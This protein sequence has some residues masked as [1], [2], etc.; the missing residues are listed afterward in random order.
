MSKR[1]NLRRLIGLFVISLTLACNVFSQAT[2]AARTTPG[3]KPGPT[4]TAVQ[5]TRPPSSGTLAATAEGTSAFGH[6]LPNGSLTVRFNEPMNPASADIPILTYPYVDGQPKWTENNSVVTFQPAKRFASD[7]AYVVSVNPYLTNT[8]GQGFNQPPTWKL[9]TPSAPVVLGHNPATGLIDDRRPTIRVAFDRAMD[10]A[11]VAASLSVTPTV[12]FNVTWEKQDGADILVIH[13]QQAF[14]AGVRYTFT[15]GRAAADAEGVAMGEDYRWS[16]WLDG[17]KVTISREGDAAD[18]PISFV[19]N[20]PMDTQSVDRAFKIDPPV[21]GNLVWDANGSRASLRPDANLTPVTTYTVSYTAN[22]LDRDGNPIA[23]PAPLQFATPP[24]VRGDANFGPDGNTSFIS[25][26]FDRAVNHASVAAAFHIEPDIPGQLHWYENTLTLQPDDGALQ[27]LSTYTITLGTSATDSQGAPFLREPFIYS[28]ETDQVYQISVGFGMGPNAQVLDSA[29]RRAVQFASN[30]KEDIPPVNFELYRLSLEQFLERYSSS[31]RGVAGEKKTPISTAGAALVTEWQTAFTA[32]PNSFGLRVSETLIPADVPPGLY[33]LKLATARNNDYLLLVLTRHTLALKQSGGQ[34]VTWVSDINGGSVAGIDVGIYARNG[35]ALAQGQT[36]AN[37]VYETSVALDPAPLIVVARSGDDVTVAGLGSEWRTSTGYWWGWWSDAPKAADYAAYIYTDRPIYRPGQ[38]VFFKAL[39]RRD[40]DAALSVPPAGVKATVRLRDARNNVASSMELETNALGSVNGQFVLSDGAMLGNNYAIEVSVGNSTFRQI[41]KVQDYR[42]PDYEVTVTTDAARYVIGDAIKVTLDTRYFFGEPVPGASLTI[43]QYEL[44]RRYWWEMDPSSGEDTDPYTWYQNFGVTPVTAQTDANGHY[45]LTLQATGSQFAQVNDWETGIKYSTWGIEVTVDDGS[46][47]TVSAF[48]VVDVYE[49]AE[50]LT[51]DVGDYLKKPGAAFTLR[52]RADTIFDTPVANRALKLELHAYDYKNWNFNTVVQTIDL[53][54]GSDGRVETSITPPAPGY[55]E[56]ALTGTDARGRPMGVQRWMYVYDRS[57]TWAGRY[58][59]GLRV[60]ADKETY[61]PGDTARLIVESAFSG[62]ALLTFER[63]ATRREQPAMLTAP[64]TV[65]NVPIQAGDAP[66]IFVAVNAWEPQDTAL[67][68]DTSTSLADSRLQSAS[69]ELSVPVTDKTLTVTLIPDKTEYTPREQAT[70]KVRVTD[71]QGKPVSAEV[72]L[73]LVDEAIFSLSDE[74]S[75]PI[76]EAFYYNR[77]NL[78][79]TYDSMQP[80]R[81]LFAGGMGGGGGGAAGAGAPRSN[82]PD[83]AAWYPELQTDANGEVSIT[84]DLPDSLT[85]WRLT[86]KAHTASTQVGEAYINV[87]TKQPIIVSPA[88]PRLL[89]AG[90]E[91]QISAIVHNYSDKVQALKVT[92]SAG[93]AGLEISGDASQALGLIPG[94]QGIITWTV[95]A[96]S[97]G[98]VPLTFRAQGDGVEDAIRLTLPIQALA[99]P[100]LHTETGEF[101][102]VLNTTVYLPD[103]ALD[104]SSVKIELSRS[105]AGSLLTGLD[106]LTGFPYGCVEQTMSRA[107]PNA[108]VGRAFVQLGVGNPTLQADLPAKI[109][110]GLQRLYGYQH[111]D[112]GWGWWYDD[113]TNDYQTAWVIF[114]LS[115]TAEA[116]YPVD[117]SVVDRGSR[118]LLENLASMDSRTRAFALYSLAQAGQGD[119]AATQTLAG[120]GGELDTFSQAALALAFHRLGAQ[121]EAQQMLDRLAEAAVQSDG[122]VYWPSPN[123]DGHYYQKTMASATR[124]T[125]LALDAFVRI[126]PGHALEPGIVRWLMS[127]RKQ[128]GWGSTNETSFTILALTDH[129]LATETA[130]AE[131]E[132]E[133]TLGGAKIASG[134][135]GRGEPAV[136]L[137]VPASQISHALSLLTIKQGGAGRLYYTISARTYLATREINAAGRVAVQRLY[138]E[139]RSGQALHTVTAG[140]LVKVQLMVD[141][142]DDGAYMLVED[143]LPGGLEALNENLNITS[144]DSAAPLT[145]NGDTIYFWQGLGY[146]YKEVRGDR[147]TFFITEMATG[148]HTFTYL[149]RATHT[150]QFAAMPVEVSAMYNPRMWGRS[151]SDVFSISN[152]TVVAPPPATPT[153]VS[154]AV[155][156][157]PTPV[158]P[159]IAVLN[160]HTSWVSSVAYS[161]DGRLIA[162]GSDDG[163]VILWDALSHSLLATLTGHTQGVL[164]VAF[165]ADGKWLASS[166]K[167]KTIHLW[168]VA[169]RRDVRTLEGHTAPVWSVA[170]SP[171][172]PQLASGSEDGTIRIWDVASGNLVRQLDS[173]GEKIWN[174]AYSVDGAAIVAAGDRVRLWQ[175]ATG[176]AGL[177]LE[178]SATPEGISYAYFSPDGRTLATAGKQLQLWDVQ[179]GQLLRTF[180]GHTAWVWSV[181]F[182]P[183]GQRLVSGSKDQTVRLWNAG[184]GELLQTYS[185][186]VG[187]ANAVAFAP[188]GSTVASA[189]TDKTVRIWRGN[190]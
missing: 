95:K 126:A 97:A 132:Y 187:S 15:L 60:S 35:Q 159:L 140:Q 46:H 89:T 84:L 16:Y 39:L 135:L 54:T 103:E 72:S 139:P 13:P 115:V 173:P 151:A 76:F 99:V 190:P 31:F 44:M 70:F 37:G 176:K 101:A 86:A 170:F 94:Q 81:W 32:T 143:H 149:A 119:L 124:S 87:I 14:A 160:G 68:E 74:L 165:S 41:L 66:N 62:P 138:L 186:H 61:A 183:D 157:T 146:N 114:G 144:H 107:L 96:Q 166:S 141:L 26:H 147:V 55:Y 42:K 9:Q 150:G 79:R 163:T 152:R 53:T 116:G 30:S 188:D 134:K 123:E 5:P 10:Q 104:L 1:P 105:I 11:S 78:V 8:K 27:S 111:D 178:A 59:R 127:Q 164:G 131:T 137:E 167:D 155:I 34:I 153:A 45:A 88:L 23:A 90:D 24:A 92:L 49:A 19:Y 98:D 189:G 69:V 181:A 43:K 148:T 175:A 22:V 33:I 64:V 67:V 63:G 48:A 28:F 50:K 142:P 100:D 3:A 18:S 83:T 7:Q 110:A 172:Q 117:Q 158:N 174:V 36:D 52:A 17:L 6:F 182:S 162:S 38:T 169:S 120:Q 154:A 180:E 106:Y 168:D 82:F 58:S 184:T 12:S 29:G 128:D 109:N 156:A 73:A 129:L 145:D 47:Q 102:G 80:T 177:T 112:G 118:W 161:P 56:W 171:T 40:D 113:E 85:S 133:V 75:G 93:T 65:I 130:S 125:A 51:L 25:L 20:Y 2:P 21:S 136:S 185:G 77:H 108:V 179:S 91:A 4:Q 71:A 57:D 122:M 121:A